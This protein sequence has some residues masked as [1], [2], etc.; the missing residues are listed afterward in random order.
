MYRFLKRHWH[1]SLVTTTG[2]LLSCWAFLAIEAELG[3]RHRLEFEWVAQDRNRALK[4]GIEEGLDAV[5]SVQNLFQASEQVDARAFDLFTKALLNRYRGIQALG[6][7]PLVTAE[8][9][10]TFEREAAQEIPGYRILEPHDCTNGG[11]T[12]P[13]GARNWYF[14][15]RYQQAAQG[16]GLFP[17]C[18]Q[19]AFP[20]RR[21]LLERSWTSGKMVVSGRIPLRPGE[22]TQFGFMAFQPVFADTLPSSGEDEHR[23][24]L[25]GF[26]VGVFRIAE[27][28]DDAMRRLEPRGVEFLLRDESAPAGAQLLDFYISR[29]NRQSDATD[30]VINP[31]W[32]L[33][34]SPKITESFPVADRLWSITCSPT[35]QF[36]SGEGFGQ[37]H[38][39]VLGGGL[40]LTLLMALFILH[41]R[42]GMRERM[43]IEE[44]LRGSEQK[45]RVLFHQSPD[46]IMTV[47]RQGCA[48]LVNRPMPGGT[49]AGDVGNCNLGF[50]PKRARE[51]FH[52]A[53]ERVF[54]G[55]ESAGLSYA[56]DDSTWWD[57]RILP[58]REGPRVS[59]AMVIAT[60]V[61]EKRLLEA[62]AI[63]TARLASLGVLAA[64]VAHE[65]NNPN[66]AIQ[67]NTSI[68]SRSWVDILRVLERHRLEQGAFT[69]G[70]VPMEKAREGIPRLL[71]GIIRSS[72]RIQYIIGNLKHMARPDQG[73]LDH[74][75][76]LEEVLQTTLSILQSQIQKHTDHCRLELP[77][78]LPAVRGNAQQLEQ[79]FINLVQNALQ[80]L[81]ER[82]AGVTLSAALEPEGERIRVRVV[83]EG[84]GISDAIKA[85]VT[86]PFFTTKGSGGT[87]LGLSISAR[88]VQAH[89]GRMEIT[90]QPGSGTEVC[91]VLPVSSN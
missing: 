70:G 40:S 26:V 6:W 12:Q 28:A 90:S 42:A 91:V 75:V 68:L 52:Q 38:W 11:P 24:S 29:L 66:N 34:N 41:T 61:T 56:G 79:V 78:S 71:E 49:D 89:S 85:R 86:D 31:S 76:D 45:L 35:H 5:R 72:Q 82:S 62:Q 23:A 57:L 22:T 36:R 88:I 81:P 37:G 8:Q 73:E 30:D 27:L 10:E 44:E 84:C 50:M 47:D 69:V 77:S 74:R 33:S 64:S 54:D 60:D 48:L 46:T 58:L 53:L 39:I 83:D 32:D 15:L 59:T 55:G 19:A 51:R 20:Q 4:K 13:A 17:G 25:R 7:L 1:V 63:R 80:A 14:P 67:F 16:R 2:I 65:I 18:D 3:E 9:R 43:R 87:G 21:V